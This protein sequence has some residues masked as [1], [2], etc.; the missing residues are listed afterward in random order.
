MGSHSY[1]TMAV[2]L[3]MG[4]PLLDISANAEKAM[5]EKYGLEAGGIILAEDKHQ[6]VFAE[7]AAKKDVQYIA[8][9]A[10]QNTI[11]V[12][13]WMLQTAGATAYMGCVGKDANGEQLKKSC[14]AD[15]VTT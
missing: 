9:G 2:I 6:P 3:G 5:F 13:Q 7:M 15:G 1:L 12:A 4:N 8:G 14:E 10:T 11:R